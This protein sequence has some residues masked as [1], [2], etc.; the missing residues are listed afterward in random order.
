MFGLYVLSRVSFLD[1]DISRHPKYSASETHARNVWNVTWSFWMRDVVVCLYMFLSIFSLV[2]SIVGLIWAYQSDRADH[3]LHPCPSRF[4]QSAIAGALVLLVFVSVGFCCVIGALCSGYVDDCCG[5]TERR[6][7]KPAANPV[8][9]KQNQTIDY[10]PVN[11]N[12]AAYG[13]HTID[14]PPPAYGST[15]TIG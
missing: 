5:F 13:H 9:I 4:Y 1:S 10:K 8:P 3:V 7:H 14:V 15:E 6:A 2:W 11:T 12:T